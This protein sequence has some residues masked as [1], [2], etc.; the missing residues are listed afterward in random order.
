[1]QGLRDFSLLL[2]LRPWQAGNMFVISFSCYYIFHTTHKWGLFACLCNTTPSGQL[3]LFDSI[4]PEVSFLRTDFCMLE[5]RPFL[6]CCGP[7][8]VLKLPD[9]G[10][11]SFIGCSSLGPQAHLWLTPRAAFQLSLW[12]GPFFLSFY[13]L[14]NKKSTKMQI[15]QYLSQWHQNTQNQ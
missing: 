5:K 13:L 12:L 6:I 9:M 7:L 2:N 11:G 3:L 4:N 15:Q 10:L 14:L 8:I 1:M